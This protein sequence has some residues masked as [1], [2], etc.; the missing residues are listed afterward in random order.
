MTGAAEVRDPRVP[1]GAIA[2]LALPS[3]LLAVFQLGRLHPDEVFQVLEPAH[4]FAFGDTVLPWEWED[5]LRNWALPGFFGWLLKACAALGI[6][7]P[8]GRRAVLEVPQ[9]A[10]HL[11]SLGAVYRMIA[12]RLPAPPAAGWLKDRSLWGAALVALHAP[13]LHYAGRT[14][15][16]AVS[17]SLLL[18][19]LER[20]ETRGRSGLQYALGGVLLGLAMVV[21]YGSL[22]IIGAAGLW[23]LG[24]RRIRDA[25]WVGLG[26]VLPL[27]L[28]GLLDWRTWGAPFHSFRAYVAYNVLSTQAAERFGAEPWWYYLP[29]LMVAVAFWAWPALLSYASVGRWA[30]AR[31][32]APIAMLLWCAVIYLVVISRVEHKE[33]RFLYPAMVFITTAAAP[34]WLWVLRGLPGRGPSIVL[35]LSFAIGLVLLGFP[36]DFNPKRAGQF[37]LFVKAARGGTGVVLLHSGS[38]GS[39]GHF[40][41]GTRP[42]VRCDIEE[43]RCLRKALANPIFNRVVGWRDEGERMLRRSGFRRVQSR[44]SAILWAKQPKRDK[45]NKGK[46]NDG[47]AERGPREL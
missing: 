13:V 20:L 42:W 39:P 5:G 22:V 18:W 37:Q 33:P 45:P 26:G 41:S 10:L 27:A 43:K 35:G 28:V 46:P 16:E 19:A 38:W 23:L 11:L 17:A 14:L 9:Y 3:A 34:T 47:L 2:W 31:P 6:D 32:P 44:G 15:G 36:S 12:R 25:F 7:D 4:Q 40:Y 8:Q 24:Q 29:W 21:R 1:W 30:Q